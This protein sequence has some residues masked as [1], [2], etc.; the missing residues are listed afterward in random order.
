MI[1]LSSLAVVLLIATASLAAADLE[2][3]ARD[4]EGKLMAPCCGANTVREHD[5]GAAMQ[6]REEIR[7]MLADGRSEQEILDLYAAQYGDKILAMPEARGF[8]L[9]PY[10][11]PMLLLVLGGVGLLIAMR[12]WR[13]GSA[14]DAGDRPLPKLDP[15]Y[16]ERLERDLGHEP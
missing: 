6:M 3:Q 9:V 7:Q 10:L 8:N 16:L 12:R 2:S 14:A 1:R 13:G 15:A 4:V 5:S 11:V